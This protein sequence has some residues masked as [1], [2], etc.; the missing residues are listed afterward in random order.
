M[1]ITATTDNKYIWYAPILA[2][3]VADSIGC[4][5][6]IL[7][8]CQIPDTVQDL[9]NDIPGACIERV[10]LPDTPAVSR[11]LIDILGLDFCKKEKYTIIV[12]ID[13]IITSS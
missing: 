10:T 13:L 9:I 7:A 8:D 1:V 3:S 2:R 4:K 6:L 12:D 11:F 5:T